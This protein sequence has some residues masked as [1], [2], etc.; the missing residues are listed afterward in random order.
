MGGGGGGAVSSGPNMSGPWNGGG[1]GGSGVLQKIT[2]PATSSQVIDFTIGT[3][4]TAGT[5]SVSLGDGGNHNYVWPNYFKCRQWSRVFQ[6]G[7][8]RVIIINF[9]NFMQR[10][11]RN[12][13]LWKYRIWHRQV[14]NIPRSEQYNLCSWRHK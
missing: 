13:I 10:W 4:G 6:Y 1:G 7:W 2:I 8:L 5:P 11:Q 12:G 3:G 14:W 9:R